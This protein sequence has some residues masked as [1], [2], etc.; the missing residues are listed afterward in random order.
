MT[1]NEKNTIALF[2][3]GVLA[4]L[5]Q[6]QT[7]TVHPWSYFHSAQEKK[8]EY[9]DGS[10]RHVTA[11]TMAR[12]YKAYLEKGFDGLKP[13]S[14]TDIGSC[15]KLDGETEKLIRYYIDEYPRLPATQIY[16]KLLSGGD[17]TKRDCSLSTLN[18]F[19]QRYKK[20]KGYT[21][22]T[23][24]KRYEKEDINELWYGDT[25][26]ASYITVDGKK[27]RVYIIAL[28]D[29]ASRMIVGC[30]AFLED[31]FISLMK[32][33]KSAVSKY[34]KPKM[35]SFDNGASYRS[36]QM[37]LLGARIG[38]AINY[39]PPYTPTSKSK[40]ERFFRT[41]KDQYL[42]LIRPN[43][44]HDIGTFEKDLK[45]WIQK[46]N[47]RPHSSL[48]GKSPNERFFSQGELILEMSRDEIERAFLLEIERKVSSDSVIVIEGKEYEVDYHYQNR[49]IQIRYS[50][51]LSNVYA[52][53]KTDGT[54]KKN[55]AA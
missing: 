55:R 46:Y 44:Y 33:L 3:Y 9:I 27:T 28:I 53:D 2:R 34:G 31:N 4:P 15:R 21:P 49:K 54:L 35:L 48:Q 18:R 38:V 51:D 23:Q 10:L 42:C 16:E 20:S 17:I 7:D 40:I 29:D 8:F 50:P 12:W 14:R 13:S 52:V 24:K 11:S 6:R 26:Y 36:R 30:G 39:C 47:T 5:I 41:L 43:D 32:V 1:E 45:K 25:T 22:V 37:A 19:V